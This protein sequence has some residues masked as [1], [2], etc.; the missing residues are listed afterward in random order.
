M[1]PLFRIA[2]AAALTLLALPALANTQPRRPGAATLQQDAAAMCRADCMA[3]MASRP[4][5]S[6]IP[7][8]QACAVRCGAQ[9][10]YLAQQ[11]QR[12]TAEA[13]GRGRAAAEPIQATPVSMSMP[14]PVAGRAT[15]GA[16]YGART[17]SAAFGM[18]VGSGDRLAAHREAE[19]VCS[20]TGQG[21]R[22]LAEFTAACG[23]AAQG[24]K[25]S[26]WALFVTSDPNSYVVTSLS[27][28]SGATQAA[29]EQQ[30][31]QECR[32]RDPQANCRIVAAACGG[33]NG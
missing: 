12:G 11:H 7:A 19:R 33:R 13:T 16:I 15:Y 28:G 20:S 25:R 6:S 8:A 1:R 18:V 26:Q 3:Q 31:M 29:A 24:Y 2:A 5:S 17:P 4:V 22:V 10:A 30:A 27:A 21:C 9:T 14:A 32:S 23:A